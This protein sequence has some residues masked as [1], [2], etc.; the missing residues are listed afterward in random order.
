MQVDVYWVIR[1]SVVILARQA[2]DL[3]PHLPLHPST[4][5]FQPGQRL[6]TRFVLRLHEVGCQFFCELPCLREVSIDR[7]DSYHIELR[8]LC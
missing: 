1:V 8:V 2:P 4:D 3:R 5:G 7:H 6:G